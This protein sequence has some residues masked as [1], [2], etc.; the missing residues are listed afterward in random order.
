MIFN[1]FQILWLFPL[2][3]VSYHLANSWVG[4]QNLSLKENKVG[5]YILLF[6]SYLLYIQW[7]TCFALVLLWI[8]FVT[9]IAAKYLGNKDDKYDGWGKILIWLALMV[10]LLPLG[11]FK[12][13]D[14]VVGSINE[15]GFFP[16][17]HGLNWAIPLGIS[18]YTFQAVGYMLDVYKRR[19]KAEN[20][21]WDYM[22]FVAFFPQ[23]LAGP[24][25]KAEELLPQIKAQRK[26]DYNKSVEGLKLLLWGMFLKVVFADRLGIY[27]DMIYSTYEHQSGLSCL[28]GSILYTFQIYGDFAGYSLMAIGSGKVLG[29]DLVENFHRPYFAASITEFWRRWHISL[30]RWLT[31]HIY[32]SLGGSRCSKTRQYWNILVTFFVSGL[33]HGAN[34]TFIVWGLIHGVFQIIEKV[35]GIDPK[36]RFSNI[37]WV[38]KLKP[39]RILI[40]FLIV[41]MAWILFR[42]PTIN[43]AVAVMTKIVSDGSLNV[44]KPNNSITFFTVLAIL[45]VM[46]KEIV[47]EFYPHKI[48]LF[49]NKRPVVRWATYITLGCMILLM[50]VFDSSQFIY[51]SF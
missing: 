43:D 22:L 6:I 30:T 3:F 38:K 5:N 2:I 40:T 29:F 51:V 50:G 15:L 4:G 1:S 48:E 46:V 13:A 41:N 27:V 24:I 7:N 34:W 17:I 12:Y 11:I 9:F 26:F 42:M 23:I 18:F 47:E 16:R 37:S 32:I 45:I 8:T 35:L 20:N 49:N 39:A 25:S 31:T 44:F 33:W 36:G 28:V 21:W 19:I 14:W 10:A